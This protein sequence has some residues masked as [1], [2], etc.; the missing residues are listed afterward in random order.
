MRAGS[1]RAVPF[2]IEGGEQEGGRRLALH[3]YP[4]RD[5]P[6][7]EDLGRRARRF[8]LDV[9]VHGDAYMAARDELV[10]ALE[11]SGPGVLI[12]PYR[13]R[14][15]VVVEAYSVSERTDDGGVARFSLTL[16][17]S[18][19]Q[20]QP[21]VSE[22]TDASILARALAAVEAATTEIDRSYSVVGER[23]ETIT[24]ALDDMT[25]VA[26]AIDGAL[27]R[28]A[29]ALA[30]DGAA[31][32]AAVRSLSANISSIVSAPG[33][34]LAAVRNISE[35][36]TQSA[37]ALA[38][39]V[40]AVALHRTILARLRPIPAALAGAGTLAVETANTR[41]VLIGVRS[42]LVAGYAEAL[43]EHPTLT[44]DDAV[45]AAT[46]IAEVLGDV[47]AE[48]V[49]IDTELA[50]DDLRGAVLRDL[51]HR[52]GELPR[53]RD[54]TPAG[55]TST[56]ELAQLLYGDATRAE[57]IERLNPTTI[58]HPGFIGDATLR[59]LT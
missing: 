24:A 38:V 5:E 54:F 36:I 51:E 17:E 19:E 3:E 37:G 52:A 27:R 6:Y 4:D 9:F 31:L 1:F 56:L 11:E 48:G 46:E 14:L 15:S 43:V 49:G 2:V 29:A 23:L 18:G 45:L 50:L 40:G 57:E 28:P 12:H 20:P 13:G 7:P 21:E 47:I 22:A 25:S 16:L 41:A 35:L 32:A 8:S 55:P 26:E 59:V 42:V 53:R 58:G 30:R 44:Y 10:A 33:D 34:F 39:S